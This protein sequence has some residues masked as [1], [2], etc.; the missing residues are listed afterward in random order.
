MSPVKPARAQQ[1][2]QRP[3]LFQDRAQ[4]QSAEPIAA[5]P[6]RDDADAEDDQLT[7]ANATIVAPEFQAR[8]NRSIAATQGPA[9]PLELCSL[10]DG[11]PHFRCCSSC[12]S[13]Y[14]HRHAF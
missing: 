12:D 10:A 14:L 7:I 4:K 11:R 8:P 1:R 5:S 9:E 13:H 2:P 3:A 6:E